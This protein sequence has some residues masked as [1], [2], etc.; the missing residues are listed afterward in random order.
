M[1]ESRLN[2]PKNIT[3]QKVSSI[4]VGKWADNFFVR[5]KIPNEISDFIQ[6]RASLTVGSKNYLDKVNLAIEFYSEIVDKF[7]IPP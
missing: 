1:A 3:N 5:N 2:V 7:P 6:G 4:T